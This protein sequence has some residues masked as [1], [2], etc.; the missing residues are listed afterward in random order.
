MLFARQRSW[1]LVVVIALSAGCSTPMGSD[2]DPDPDANSI[3]SGERI[4]DLASIGTAGSVIRAMPGSETGTVTDP[5]TVFFFRDE[6]GDMMHV[7]MVCTSS[8]VVSEIYIWN[9]PEN[10]R[11]VTPEG[12]SV[13][14]S[15]SEVLATL[16][17]P[18]RTIEATNTRILE[19][20]ERTDG[21]YGLV[22][23]FWN[24]DLSST[25]F[26]GVRGPCQ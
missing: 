26:I 12:L 21:S 16:G 14:S 25:H 18:A 3:V 13:V 22:F 19:Y 1:F 11:F 15:E 23:S 8:D 2:A 17:T 7:I 20:D 6:A 24:A 9:R 5:L 4:G 10:E